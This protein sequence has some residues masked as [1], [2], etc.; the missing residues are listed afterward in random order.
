VFGAVRGDIYRIAEWYGWNGRE[1]EGVKMQAGDIAEGLLDRIDDWGLKGR[2]RPGPADSAIFDDYE[3]TH[4]V[5][6]DMKLKGVRWEP[7]DKGPGSRKHGWLQVR[8]YLKDALPNVDG[9]R[10]NPGLFV[11]DCCEQ[12]IRTVP[13][14]P[15]SDKDLDDVDTEV[16]DHVGDEVRYRLRRKKRETKQGNF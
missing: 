9:P 14:L 15:R 3:P 6:G 11:C 10:E 8:K 7:A 1:N 16:E 4:S 5:A 12:F 13:V 2:V